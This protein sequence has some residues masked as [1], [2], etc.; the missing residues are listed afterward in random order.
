MF[1]HFHHNDLVNVR[2][3]VSSQHANDAWL[4]AATSELPSR[5]LMASTPPR[6]TREMVGTMPELNDGLIQ[7]LQVGTILLLA[8]WSLG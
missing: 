6:T 7:V 1:A 5:R 8:R 3:Q 2:A 4:E